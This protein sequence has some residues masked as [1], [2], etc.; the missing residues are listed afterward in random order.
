MVKLIPNDKGIL[1]KLLYCLLCISRIARFS[2]AV[3]IAVI[4]W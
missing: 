3:N 1:F 2:Y 4:L